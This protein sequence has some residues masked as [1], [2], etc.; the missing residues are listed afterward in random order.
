MNLIKHIKLEEKYHKLDYD[1]IFYSFSLTFIQKLY[2]KKTE[3]S[4]NNYHI[5][6]DTEYRIYVLL[7]KR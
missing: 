5:E 2:D 3:L 6:Y 4:N 7:R 1:L